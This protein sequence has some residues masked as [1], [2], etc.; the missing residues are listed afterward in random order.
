MVSPLTC[1]QVWFIRTTLHAGAHGPPG[2]QST[3]AVAFENACLRAYPWYLP[4]LVS[5]ALGG[6]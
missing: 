2:P 1:L 4:K 3:H 5:V 6:Q